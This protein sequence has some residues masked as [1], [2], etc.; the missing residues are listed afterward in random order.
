[1]FKRAE[2]RKAKFA[3]II[4]ENEVKEGKIVIKDLTSQEQ[5]EIK[6]EELIEKIYDIHDRIYDSECPDCL[7]K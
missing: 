1:M 4:G 6:Q 2:H 7:E 5:M 3:I